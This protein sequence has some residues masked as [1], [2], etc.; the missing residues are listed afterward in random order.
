MTS[1]SVT[2]L[3]SLYLH[4]DIKKREEKAVKAV[5]VHAIYKLAFC[6]NVMF[7]SL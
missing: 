4:A 1:A 2:F 3:K 7:V 6:S 5:R